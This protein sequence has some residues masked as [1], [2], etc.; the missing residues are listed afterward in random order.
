M[1]LTS[2]GNHTS[3]HRGWTSGEGGGEI[4]ADGLPTGV[5]YPHRSQCLAAGALVPAAPLR[6]RDRQPLVLVRVPVG[7]FEA[8][9]ASAWSCP[10]GSSSEWILS[11]SGA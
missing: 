10:P 4:S 8:K 9:T 6:C 7:F 5:S 3:R 11:W 1:L 2:A